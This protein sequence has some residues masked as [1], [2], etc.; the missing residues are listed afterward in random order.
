MS[1]FAV[2]IHSQGAVIDDRQTDVLRPLPKR[3]P[4]SSGLYAISV[5]VITNMVTGIPADENVLGGINLAMTLN[6]LEVVIDPWKG[7]DRDD[8]MVQATYAGESPFPVIADSVKDTELNERLFRPLPAAQLRDGLCELRVG[9]RRIS[10]TGGEY[11]F[12][13]PLTLL[14]KTTL[15]G[16]PDPDPMAPYHQSLPQIQVDKDVLLN[17]VTKDYLDEYNGL[18]CVIPPYLFMRRNSVIILHYGA[19]NVSLPRVTAAQVGSPIR[20]TIPRSVIEREGTAIPVKLNHSIMDVVENRTAA[21][22]VPVFF[23]ANPTLDLLEA[24]IVDRAD[25]DDRLDIVALNGAD[26]LTIVSTRKISFTP[27]DRVNRRWRGVDFGG[28]EVPDDQLWEPSQSTHTHNFLVPYYKARLIARGSAT[29]DYQHTRGTTITNSRRAYVTVTGLPVLLLPPE[30]PQAVGGSVPALTPLAHV[31]VKSQPSAIILGDVVRVRW[32]VVRADA[33]QYTYETQISVS[34]ALVDQDIVFDI[35]A[36][37]IERGDGGRLTVSYQVFRF[38]VDTQYS[39]QLLLF[40]GD[41]LS[42]LPPPEVPAV[43]DEVLV[44]ENVPLGAQA[45][46]KPYDGMRDQDLVKLDFVGGSPQA[47]WSRTWDALTPEE[48]G[49]D[50]I[51]RIPFEVLVANRNQEVSLVYAVTNRFSGRVRVSQKLRFRIAMPVPAPDITR[52]SDAAGVEIPRGSQTF[53]NSATLSGSAGVS[54]PVDIRNNGNMVATVT[55]TPQRTWSYLVTPLAP[56]AYSFTVQ[57]PGS[58]RPSAAWAF[59]ALESAVPTISLVRTP[60]ERIPHNGETYYQSR[61]SITGTATSGQRIDIRDGDTSL[62]TVTATGGVWTLGERNFTVGR[63]AI[64]AASTDG[65]NNV[66]SPYVFTVREGLWDDTTNFSQQSFNN[67]ERGNAA[68]AGDLTLFLSPTQGQY[69]LKNYRTPM[70]PPGT[71]CTRPSTISPL[72]PPTRSRYAS[73]VS[74]AGMLTRFCCCARMHR[75]VRV[76]TSPTTPCRTTR[77]I[78]RPPPLDRR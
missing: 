8:F 22:S 7:M 60:D 14:I 46:I 16:G 50:L 30:V 19:Q 61:I 58:D 28:R 37:E 54:V 27:G 76:F 11:E 51:E 63:H 13:S 68:P 5:P 38:N 49:R 6:E 75:A 73:P 53:S 10:N 74:T 33:S 44:P 47:S 40:I 66:S 18:P 70:P 3:E 1:I 32:H 67:W 78:S 29:V 23:N 62:G 42:E 39:E 56:G 35:P 64:T 36:S 12:G 9:V 31:I 15:P 24:P 26:V 2:P 55:S 41:T 65:S 45:I 72:T 59:T 34:E 4:G 25:E 20:F 43:R 69:V 48:A 21:P 71:Y 17:G 52:V 77:C 57:T